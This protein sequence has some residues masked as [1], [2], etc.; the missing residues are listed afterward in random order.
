MQQ[1]AQN[2][3]HELHIVVS[4]SYATG[5]VGMGFSQ[6]GMMVGSSA[7][8]G[9]IGKTGRTHIKQF[10]LKGQT[11]SQVV[12]NEG[13]LLTSPNSEPQVVVE[14]AK[15]YLAFKLNFPNKVTTQQILF[16]FGTSIPVDNKLQKHV[17]KT[18]MAFDFSTGLFF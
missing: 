14:Q 13:N 17:D 11:S 15:I 6:S 4:T 5:W 1:Y 16:A 7:I 2:K 3:D 12:V 18:S 8:V 10:F 9:W